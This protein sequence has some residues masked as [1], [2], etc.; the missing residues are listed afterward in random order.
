M[1]AFQPRR[2]HVVRPIDPVAFAA[3]LHGDLL[4][5]GTDAYEGARQ[6]R[7][8][9][10]DL[11][12]GA[13]RP[14]GGCGGR[15]AR[16]PLRRGR[17]ARDRRPQRR[18][19]PR[20]LRHGRRRARHRHDRA[21]GH[22]HRPGAPAGLGRL[23]PDRPRIHDRGRGPRARDAVR[24]HGIGRDRRADPRRWHRLARSQ[25]RARHRRPARRRDR[26][27][28]RPDPDGQRGRP[29]RPVLG[30]PRRWRQ[31]RH[32]HAV[33][34]RAVPGRGD[35]RWRAVHAGDA[36]GPRQPGVDR[37]GG[38]RGA[39][40]DLLRHA[41]AAGPVRA[42]A[43]GR[44]S[45]G[46]D[47]VRLRRRPGR[48]TGRDRAVPAGGDPARRAGRPDAVSRDLR[49]PRGGRAPRLRGRPLAVPRPHRRR[50][51]RWPCSARSRSRPR[52]WR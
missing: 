51:G 36:R 43:P 25:V 3:Q 4:V 38:S 9:D 19:Q 20:R 18:P 8:A 26:H 40:D 39:D 12:P 14:R 11:H 10:F 5:P 28:R 37:R 46:R 30:G 52:R 35:L 47:H 42:R 22:P 17:G 44:A 24:R 7:N 49:A 15:L 50:R 29:P 21:Q 27:G 1:E 32:R 33:P 2:Q 23:R 6:I 16:G 45:V 41:H 34:L 13:D 31:L 48:R